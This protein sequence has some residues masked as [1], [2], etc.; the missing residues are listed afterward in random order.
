MSRPR[1]IIALWLSLATITVLEGQSVAQR[2]AA[3]SSSATIAQATPVLDSKEDPQNVSQTLENTI[4]AEESSEPPQRKLVGW[5]EYQGPYF[6]GRFGAGL[7][8]EV[9]GFAQD[10]NSKEQI[11]MHPDER[12]RDF[13]FI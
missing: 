7:L 10:E 9:A 13:R 8:L 4:D 1:M 5:N 3:Q 12:L 11:K 6:T 2:A